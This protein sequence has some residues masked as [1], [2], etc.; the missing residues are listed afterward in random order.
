MQAGPQDSVAAASDLVHPHDVHDV[1]TDAAED[2]GTAAAERD[3]VVGVCAIDGVHAGVINRHDGDPYHEK[4][5]RHQ[6][7]VGNVELGGFG[8]AEDFEE[9]AGKKAHKTRDEKT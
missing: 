8:V 5:Q 6:H 9:P 3:A 1:Q 7:T 4:D 2:P